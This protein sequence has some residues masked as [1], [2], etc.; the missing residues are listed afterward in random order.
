M[1]EQPEQTPATDAVK[2]L[3][4]FIHTP[5]T[6]ELSQKDIRTQLSAAGVNMD[7]VKKRYELLLTQAKGRAVLASARTERQSFM[8]RM[9]ELQDRF[10]EAGDVRAQVREFVQEVFGDRP[11][12]A[13]AWR[14]FEHA[15]DADLRTMVEDL[16]LLEAL[17]KD[18]SSSSQT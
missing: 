15:T 14:N 16:T 10:A 13:V 6:D 11:E 5:Q 3:A 12:A 1:P 2:A 18:D 8:A 4:D 17:E 9:V 7:R